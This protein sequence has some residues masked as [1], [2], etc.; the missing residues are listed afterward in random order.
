M[1]NETNNYYY[2]C[3]GDRIRILDI[4]LRKSPIRTTNSICSSQ[5]MSKI[6]ALCSSNLTLY[7]VGSMSNIS[8]LYV[9]FKLIITI[10][11]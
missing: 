5:S 4:G 8:K 6:A 11:R 1:Y 3:I 10:H 7:Q 2:I 9:N